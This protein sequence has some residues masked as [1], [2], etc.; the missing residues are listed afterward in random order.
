MLP[1]SNISM[2][3]RGLP[4]WAVFLCCS[5]AANY[6][7]SS[8]DAFE[9]LTDSGKLRAGDTIVWK[10][11]EYIDVE[12]NIDSVDG[13]AEK[14]ITM[15]AATP[16]GVVLRGESKINIGAKWWVIDGFHFDGKSGGVNA[17]NSVQ[18]RSQGGK[19]AEHVRLTRCA[20][21]DLTC[22]DESS[23]W[24]QIYGRF[25]RIDHCHFSGKNSKGA[26]ITIELGALDVDETA[27]HRI[28][29]NYFGNIAPQEGTDNE[30]I[31]VGFSGDQNKKSKCF[32]QSNLFVKCNGENEIISNKSSFNTYYSNTFRG[33]NGALVLRHG[34]HAHVEGNYFFGD[35]ADNAGGIRIVDSHHTVINNYMQDLTGVTWNSALSIMGGKQKSGGKDNG[36]QAVDDIMVAHNTIVN[37][38][39]S[40]FLN[41]AKGTRGPTG[42]FAN[43]LI[44]SSDGPLIT[45]KL[46]V[47]G[48]KWLSN[49][50]HG[51]ELGAKIEVVDTDPLMKMLGGMY[52]LSLKSPAIDAAGVIPLVVS[53]DIDGQ[54]RP[55][56]KLDIGAD[57]ATTSRAKAIYK[58]LNP[59]DVGVSYLQK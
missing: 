2:I 34:H 55:D 51:A 20:L 18:F 44:S 8:G 42:I 21:T 7:V 25:N 28:E 47:N 46:S 15:R 26:L 56:S 19:R 23:K 54:I 50:M 4:I 35:G 31:R 24:I 14:P 16:G 6:E 10:D 43:N 40:I 53:K 57:E 59:V 58:P 29:M 48:I 22:E 17:Y 39:R 45:E 38:R 1:N 49:L 9:E 27:E 11:G 13:L 3:L 12:L 41:D 52:R 5:H 30:T 37:C 36:Y 33:C 32:I